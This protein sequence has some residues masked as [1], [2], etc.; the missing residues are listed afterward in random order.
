MGEMEYNNT[1]DNSNV[2]VSDSNRNGLS[3]PVKTIKVP[4]WCINTFQT[5]LSFTFFTLI[6]LFLNSK[7][8]P[9]LKDR[10]KKRD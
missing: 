9:S 5:V 2:H 4:E 6:Q 8:Y 7:K 10:Y 3:T 1:N